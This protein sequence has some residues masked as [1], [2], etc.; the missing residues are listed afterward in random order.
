MNEVYRLQLTD[1]RQTVSVTRSIKALD[2]LDRELQE[3][4]AHV[5]SAQA[6][7]QGGYY[8]HSIPMDCY[9]EFME[10][11]AQRMRGEESLFH[12][13]KS[14]LKYVLEYAKEI[15]DTEL[16][17]KISRHLNNNTLLH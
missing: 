1:L 4:L 14:E 16:Y 15:T 11:R 13:D 9:R 17:N 7:N 2:S 8:A 6:K 5:R 12:F 3:L 10:E